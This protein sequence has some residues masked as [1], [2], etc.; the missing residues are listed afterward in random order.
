[1]RCLIDSFPELH[2]HE[3]QSEMLGRHITGIH[4]LDSPT[5]AVCPRA[6]PCPWSEDL[7]LTGHPNR[8][9]MFNCEGVWHLVK[10][11]KL[12]AEC[13]PACSSKAWATCTSEKKRKN[14]SSGNSLKNVSFGKKYY[15]IRNATTCKSDD[16]TM[17]RGIGIY[18]YIYIYFNRS[19]LLCILFLLVPTWYL[20]LLS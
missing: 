15:Q 4:W 2:P 8:L 7:P 6:S 16:G 10:A 13:H 14:M 1:M 11:G 20:S 17:V 9:D 5:S 18:K 12:W 19:N 3:Q